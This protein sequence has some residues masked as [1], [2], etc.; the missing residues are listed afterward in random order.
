MDSAVR[1]PGT[2]FRFGLDP[3]LGL[4]PGVGDAA[5]LLISAYILYHGHRLRLPRATLARMYG[6][7][8][9][10]AVLGTVP[11]IGDAFDFAFKAHKKNVAL[12]ERHIRKQSRSFRQQR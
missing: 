8:L 4:A 6:N 10:D 7:I 1:I 12:I 3:I 2:Q 9:L 11:V 5:G